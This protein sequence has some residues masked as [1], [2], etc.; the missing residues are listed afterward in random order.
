MN[1]PKVLTAYFKLSPID[2]LQFNFAIP[3]W[4]DYYQSYFYVNKIEEYQGEITKVE[5]IKI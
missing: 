2:I 1:K 4:I 3:V 5:L